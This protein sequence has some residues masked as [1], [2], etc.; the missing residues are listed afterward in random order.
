MTAAEFTTRRD[1][2]QRLALGGALMATLPRIL[3]ENANVQ[4][5]EG[6]AQ[7]MSDHVRFASPFS[8]ITPSTA[9]TSPAATPRV[10]RMTSDAVVNVKLPGPTVAPSTH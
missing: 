8:S 6:E 1:F 7:K 10:T 3:A 9:I 4:K 5:V 2:L